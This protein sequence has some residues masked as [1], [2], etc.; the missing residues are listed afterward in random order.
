MG[1]KVDAIPGRV[2]CASF[3][4]LK[5]GYF[6][7]QCSELC[8]PGHGF[9]PIVVHGVPIAVFNYLY[10]HALPEFYALITDDATTKQAPHQTADDND[11]KLIGALWYNA[12]TEVLI[13]SPYE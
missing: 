3:T 11:F 1:I 8:G 5:S 10:K 6:V 9:M 13:A 4:L 2:N 7:G 12:K